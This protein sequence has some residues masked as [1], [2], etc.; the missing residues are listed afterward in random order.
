M[1]SASITTTSMIDHSYESSSDI[2]RTMLQTVHQCDSPV[3]HVFFSPSN[4]NNIQTQLRIIVKEK[5]GY[6]IGRQD[7]NELLVI[8]RAMYVLYASQQKDGD[9]EHEVRRLNS[10]VITQV[11]PQIG[12][13]IAAYLG[14]TR[15]AATM[16]IPLERPKNMS[17][18]GTNTF[19]LF[20]GL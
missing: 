17:V 20:K 6:T 2:R 18:K 3:A 1:S 4:L 5:T 7:D 12:S 16:Y 13:G 19:E 8:M 10:L 14:Y 15:D 11:L 9:V